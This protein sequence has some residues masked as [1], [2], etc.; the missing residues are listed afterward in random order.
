MFEEAAKATRF[1]QKNNWPQAKEALN[2]SDAIMFDHKI[3]KALVEAGYADEIEYIKLN[4]TSEEFNRTLKRTQFDQPMIK[5]TNE[6]ERTTSLDGKAKVVEKMN[7]LKNKFSEKYGGYLDE[8]SIIPDK[9]GKPIFKSSA[10][11][12]T[13]QTDFISALGK[14]MVQAGEI[15][16]KDQVKLFKKNGLS[17]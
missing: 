9:T 17:L 3:P 13:K 11:P 16:K 6:F 14:S 15:S 10:A 4:P 12:V 8:V 5:L 1:A 7:K 2:I